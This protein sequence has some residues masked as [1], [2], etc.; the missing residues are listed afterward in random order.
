[1]A[2]KLIEKALA[3]TNTEER[4]HGRRTAGTD[5]STT[6]K[7]ALYEAHK[8][9]HFD[10]KSNSNSIPVPIN[11][12]KEKEQ[13]N[14]PSQAT[15][16]NTSILVLGATGRTGLETLRALHQ[17]PNKPTLHAFCRSPD[18]LSAQDKALCTTIQQGNA[19]NATDLENALRQSQANY[20]VV[21]IGNGDSV[22]KSDIRTANAQALASVLQRREFRHVRVMIV[23]STGAGNS[24]II[25]GFGIGAMISFHLR[26]VLKDHTGQEQAFQQAHLMDRTE[27]VRATALVD[28]KSTGQPLVTF[29]DK[30][31]SPSIE[32]DRTDLA[33]WIAQAICGKQQDFGNLIV[34]VTGSKK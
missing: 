1:M 26:H 16:N 22:A 12:A 21:S 32:T 17:Q 19:R 4:Q 7:G 2:R 11:T 5:P 10:C 9:N 24:D 6:Q 13:T 15:S 25:V 33:Q 3:S 34:N 29:A 31:K 18:K 30:A 27:I 28:G 14:M 20:V 23:S 8:I